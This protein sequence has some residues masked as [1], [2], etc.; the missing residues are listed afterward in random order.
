MITFAFAIKHDVIMSKNS[1]FTGQPVYNQVLKL[2][3]RE[4]IMQISR[5]TP[6][7]EA[8]VKRLDGYQHLV[9]MLYGVLKHFDSLRELEIGM[10]AEA[11]KLHHLGL[12]YL[13]R[14]STLAEANIR[15]PQEFFSKVYAN[16]LE[17]YACFLADSR[18]P[19]SYKGQTHEPKD[20]EKLLYMMDS[21]TISLFD[22]ILKG[23][24]R[25]PKS[26]KKKGG[27]KV[28][29]VM[30]YYVGVPMVVQLTSAAKHDHYLLK[31]V[32]L[33][34][35]STLT[36][37]RGY[38]DIAQF[39]RLT[40]EGVCYVTKMKKNLKYEVLDSVIYVNTD[41][42][43]THID[44]RVRFTRG[45]LTHVAR[46]V[47]IF[48]E[49]KKPVTLLTNNFEFSV[50]DVSEIYRLRWAIESLYKQLKQ[51]FP[52]H[53]FYGDS[54]NAIQIQTWVVLIANLLITVLSRSIKRKCAFSQ[55]VTMIRLTLMYYIDF[56][57]FME[58]PDK[59]W[60]DIL[61]K[62]SQKAPPEPTLFD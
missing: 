44:Q 53:F 35:D 38:I 23:V 46:R 17:Q 55:V 42:L 36:M 15:R 25:H 1:N 30:K 48:E 20:W 4:K 45:E 57:R 5:E 28:H 43:V 62:E 33:P 29:T 2:L 54:I 31:E 16:L 41:G 27:M 24:G 32:H 18:P 10:K 3:N 56:V 40:E 47:E 26:G 37:D 21:T 39:Q 59:T 49:R 13:V 51:N 7:S 50:E 19:K 34:K 14:R 61:A 52:L 58:N 9:V 11:N 60:D 12:D 22:N 6:G 8:Y